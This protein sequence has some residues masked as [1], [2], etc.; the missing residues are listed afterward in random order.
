MLS[1]D[2]IFPFLASY[3]IDSEQRITASWQQN[4]CCSCF[5]MNLHKAAEKGK[6]DRVRLLVEQGV[7]KDKGSSGGYSPL[8]L[9]SSNGHLEVVQYLVEQ[10]AS[11][12]KASN[13]GETPLAIAADNGCLEVVRYL[14]EQGADRDKA[15]TFGWTP[16]HHAAYSRLEIA[17]LL[18]SYG[19]DLNARTKEGELPID[20]ADT[21]EMKQAIRDEPR[22][23]MDHGHKRATEQ[24]R[25]PNATVS[26]SAQQEE[27][28]EEQSNKRPRIDEGGVAAVVPVVAEEET[29]VAEEDEDSEPSSDEE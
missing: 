17:M 25:H 5:K 14:L 29:K 18:M 27:E 2:Y 15:S 7:D 23:R 11:L 9:A 26:A 12:D 10:G 16:L 28:E 3:P 4:I 22:R 8:Y 1:V 21:E 6:L 20:F 24:D 19:A 13:Y